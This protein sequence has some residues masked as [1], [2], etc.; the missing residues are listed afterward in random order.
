MRQILV[1]A[2]CAIVLFIAGPAHAQTPVVVNPTTLAFTPSADHSAIGSDGKPIVSRYELRISVEGD[3]VVLLA[4][5]LGKPTP[6]NNTITIVNPLWF[7]GL[8]PNTKYLGTVAAI[9]PT[10]EGVSRPAAFWECGS[11]GTT[12][13]GAPPTVTW[14]TPTSGPTA[15]GTV[16]T[17]T[18]TGFA[19]GATVTFGGIAATSVAVATATQLTATTSAHAAGA[20]AA[21]ITNA[22]GQAGTFALGFTYLAPV[23]PVN[24]NGDRTSDVV[25][26]RHA[27]GQWWIRGQSNPVTFG[28]AGDVPVVADYDGDGKADLAVYRPSTSEWI[29]QNQRT[30][31]FGQAGDVPVPGDYNGDGKTEIAV[32]RPSTG[33]WLVEGQSTPTPWGMRGDV[34]VPADY[35]GDGKT[36]IAVYR[37]TTGVWYIAER[38]NGR[39]GDVGRRPGGG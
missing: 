24:L 38:R 23:V 31:V 13:A 19:A 3:N 35:N 14:V 2:A 9:G 33:E 25:V 6:V 4:I 32:F 17:M 12:C 7:A 27:T 26:F 8:T 29:I 10:G 22:D 16:V 28:Q 15:G 11:T 18:G 36:E 37:P 39:V 1:A 5:D 34:P 30:V 21:V 20:V